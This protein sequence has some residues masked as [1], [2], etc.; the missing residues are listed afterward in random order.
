MTNLVH[1]GSHN[2]DGSF[3]GLHRYGTEPE[4]QA[5]M[6]VAQPY[7]PQQQVHRTVGQ[8]KLQENN[9]N[10]HSKYSTGHY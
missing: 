2:K 8:E 6:L 9:K 4:V 10:C 7:I 1:M 5:C 3:R